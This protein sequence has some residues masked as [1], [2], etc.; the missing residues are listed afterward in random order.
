MYLE[1]AGQRSNLLCKLTTETRK[2][3]CQLVC[4]EGHRHGIGGDV[5]KGGHVLVGECLV[6][7][8]ETVLDAPQLVFDVDKA[9]SMDV[10]KPSLSLPF[11]HL[12]DRGDELY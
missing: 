3:I 5:Q 7:A 12:S 4:A 1:S 11:S 6:P 10:R 9:D 8:D 2:R